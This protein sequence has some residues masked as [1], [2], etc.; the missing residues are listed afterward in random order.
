MSY[1]RDC[2]C[3]PTSCTRPLKCRKIRC[4]TDCSSNCLE[5]LNNEVTVQKKIWFKNRV[6]ESEYIMNLSSLTVIGN[7]TYDPSN[8]NN[9][10]KKKYNYVNWNQSSDRAVPSKST[11]YIPRIKTSNR[12][13]GTSSKG[14]GV[15]IKHNSYARYLAKKKANNLQTSINGND[16][17]NNCYC[18]TKNKN[19]IEPMFG[20]KWF[21]VGLIQRCNTINCCENK[22]YCT[23]KDYNK[24]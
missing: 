16:N 6:Q 8:N 10:P 4:V 12:P 24:Q 17:C 7:R 2:K 5:D 13:G 14:V 1:N 3:K 9:L 11:N 15:D 23:E 20:N 21:A 18:D 22:L 19:C